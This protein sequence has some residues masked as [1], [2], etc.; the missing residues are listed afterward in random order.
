MEIIQSRAC[1]RERASLLTLDITA[2]ILCDEKVLIFS[3]VLLEAPLHLDV[4]ATLRIPP[5][6]L[7]VVEPVGTPGCCPSP[8]GLPTSPIKLWASSCMMAPVS[9]YGA[10]ILGL[11]AGVDRSG[12]IDT[13]LRGPI[14]GS[15]S[16]SCGVIPQRIVI[17]SKS[18]KV[19]NVCDIHRHTLS[20]RNP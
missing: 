16:S 12:R 15:S 2:I 1:T 6:H 5:L 4:E 9:K 7:G 3:A 11:S 8:L 13:V 20:S 19:N 18:L 10:L 14:S 17:G